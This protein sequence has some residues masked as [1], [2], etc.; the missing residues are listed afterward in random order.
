ME[1]F[2]HGLLTDKSSSTLSAQQ[3][4]A[5][6]AGRSFG[7]PVLWMVLDGIT[8]LVSTT[9]ATLY[10]THADPMA[11]VRGFWHGTLIYGRSMGI[12]LAF[13]CGFCITLI[14]S[15]HWLHLYTP[16]RLSGMLHEQKLN[17]QACFTAGLL[18]TGA[19][20]L[21]KAEDIPRRVVLITL[22][23][24]TISLGV[25]RLVY[26]S[27]LYRA[28]ERGQT[29]R[30]VLIVGT[31]PEAK[32]LRNHL[33]SMRHLGYTFKG[34]IDCADSNSSL[35]DTFGDVVGTIDTLFDQTRRR[36]IDD[37]FVTNPC[38]RKIVHELLEQARIH[39]V[40]LRVVPDMY[41]GQA[42]ANPIEYIGQFPT[43]PLHHGYL[44]E[45]SLVIKRALDIVISSLALLILAPVL[46]AVAAAIK[47][48]SAGPVF[49]IS[50][51]I[52]KKGYSFRCI[53]FRT[54]IA[55]ADKRRSD[56]MHLNERDGVLFKI[57]NDPR[58]TELGRFLRKYSLDELPQLFN[59]L[60]GDMSL[61]GPRP[62][63]AG[64]VE[65]YKLS[66]L[67]RLD[68]PPGITGLWQVEARR[69]PS[70]DS[71]ISIDVAYI[72]NWSLL[73]DFKIIAR[74]VG[75]VLAGTGS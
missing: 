44:P 9:L 65:E 11:G 1:Q 24:V 61:V 5:K 69:D 45:I 51:R 72:E 38:E 63:L 47:L 66:H 10:A 21:I 36:F 67:R 55:D 3:F 58:I 34:F 23:A 30:N 32:A 70:F 74:T 57:A 15:S 19:L 71:Y 4:S 73:L 31:G 53:K 27:I 50:E 16:R 42:L 14:L 43:I 25:R 56:L 41:E 20:Y 62:P 7:Q 2:W 68:V 29:T 59:V 6:P 46:V 48:D 37:I 17:I 18:L 49:Y 26:R 12:L 54:M 22:G 39:R 28:F 8:V 35:P 33:V 60:S 52:G 64:E 75:V 13:V 40:D